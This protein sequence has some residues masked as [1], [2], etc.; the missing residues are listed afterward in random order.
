MLLKFYIGEHGID[1]CETAPN[2]FIIK[3]AVERVCLKF[4][5]V[6]IVAP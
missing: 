6:F 5:I 4:L 2:D 1:F 3:H